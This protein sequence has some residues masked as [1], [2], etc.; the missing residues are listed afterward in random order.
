MIIMLHFSV[1]VTAQKSEISKGLQYFTSKCVTCHSPNGSAPFNLISYQDIASKRGIIQY[2]INENLMP[3][4]LADTTY[5]QFK[6]CR[7][8]SEEE[9]VEIINWVKS[10]SKSDIMPTVQLD[11]QRETSQESVINLEY[12]YPIILSQ[13]PKDTDIAF[14]YSYSLD[15]SAE[16]QQIVIYSSELQLLHHV[17]LFI[18]DS[19]RVNKINTEDLVS[20]KDNY[21]LIY[22]IACGY[23]PGNKQEPFDEGYGMVLPKSGLIR[24]D[25]HFSPNVFK[26]KSVTFGVYFVKSKQPIIHKLFLHSP[27]KFEEN[28]KLELEPNVEKF[29]KVHYITTK[30]MYV[31][32]CH[33]HMHVFGKS[34]LSYAI[35][36]ENDTLKIIKIDKWNFYQQE[37]YEF[38]TPLF[39]PRGS[40]IFY[41]A[42]YDNTENNPYNPYSPPIY[43]TAGVSTNQEMLLNYFMCYK[44]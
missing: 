29:F 9:R 11:L 25:I 39:I 3:P 30:D 33:P 36:P 8:L 44:K 4:W 1:V 27:I 12:P 35:T 42:W 5:V 26:E 23:A 22:D 24:G 37:F 14:E 6:N 31:K 7:A 2:V 18:T 21:M 10:L 13:N 41:E 38:I 40:K 16:I 15:A 32:Y 19:A 28:L 34:F 20:L 43:V 17:N